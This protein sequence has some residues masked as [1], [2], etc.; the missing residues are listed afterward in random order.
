MHGGLN[1]RMNRCRNVGVDEWIR[2][3]NFGICWS[4][5]TTCSRL[6]AAM[7]APLASMSS[8]SSSSP[9]FCDTPPTHPTTPSHNITNR[10]Q[11]SHRQ[12]S[13]SGTAYSI[14]AD[15]NPSGEKIMKKNQRDTALRHAPRQPMSDWLASTVAYVRM[16]GGTHMWMYVCVDVCM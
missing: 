10:T 6:R 2:T 12:V 9:A 8:S 11:P 14:D 5:L 13:I 16:Y 7:D 4:K 15:N 3:V 1:E